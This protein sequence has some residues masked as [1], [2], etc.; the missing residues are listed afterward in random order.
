ML[1]LGGQLENAG[2]VELLHL[3]RSCVDAQCIVMWESHSSWCNGV[4]LWLKA[5]VY[6]QE[7][8]LSALPFQLNHCSLGLPNRH[9]RER[10]RFAMSVTPSSTAGESFAT[11]DA[12]YL[13]YLE[14]IA[15]GWQEAENLRLHLSRAIQHIDLW[16]SATDRRVMSAAILDVCVD[17]TGNPATVNTTASLQTS[18]VRNSQDGTVNVASAGRFFKQLHACRPDTHLR[19][20]Y[21]RNRRRRFLDHVNTLLFCHIL[22][23]EL[24]L[25]P[26]QVCVLIQ[27]LCF[28]LRAAN[29]QL[30]RKRI[31]ALGV[32]LDSYLQLRDPDGYCTSAA[33]NLGRRKVGDNRPYVGKTFYE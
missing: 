13:K 20:V 22:G 32:A 28:T 14:G 27:G 24:D 5:K 29:F 26:A 11:K 8:S 2:V 25:R 10:P 17:S 4:L 31:H 23:I 19:I 16:W 7:C 33:A 30:S 21:A 12:P 18:D 15:H 3:K 6:A 9:S 1:R